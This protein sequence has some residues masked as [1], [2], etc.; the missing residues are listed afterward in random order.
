[1]RLC[2]FFSWREILVL[3]RLCVKPNFIGSSHNE[4]KMHLFSHHYSAD[5]AFVSPKEKEKEEENQKE[6]EKEK[7]EEKE[8]EQQKEGAAW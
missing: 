8:E 1:L 2:E 3:P 6:K 5:K 7:E 4:Q